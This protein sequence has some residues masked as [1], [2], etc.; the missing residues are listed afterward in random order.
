VTTV[1][2]AQLDLMVGDIAGNAR[3]VIDCAD[4]LRGR[5]DIVVFP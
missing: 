3:R 1:A 5:A 4:R 2:L